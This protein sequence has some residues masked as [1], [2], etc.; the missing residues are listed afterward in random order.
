M[1]FKDYLEQIP[2]ELLH[3]NSLRATDAEVQAAIQKK[4]SSLDDFAALLSPTAIK[5]LEMM[6]MRSQKVT[7]S[8]F[9]KI[10]QL[11]APLYVSNECVDT[12]TYCGFSRENKIARRTLTLSEIENETQ[13][14]IQ[15]GIKHILIVAGEHPH[16]VPPAFFETLIK[17]LKVPSISLEVAPQKESVYCAWVKAGA[18]GL[19]IYQETYQKENYATYHLAGKKKDFDYRLE[20]P[21]RAARAGMKR[22]GIGI[23]LGLS[24]WRKDALALIAH[25]QFLQ[26]Y[27]YRSQITISLPRLRPAA[28]S[29]KPPYPI[30]DHEFVQ[31]I[32]AIRLTLPDTGIVLSTREDSRLR[33]ALIQIGITHMSAG[34]KTEPG[35]YLEPRKAEE[36]FQIEDLRSV[37]E[38]AQDIKA[39]GYEAVLK[40]W[41]YALN[42]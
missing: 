11:Y 7:Q 12:C 8:R 21:E 14:L 17:K 29:F 2:I 3:E 31:L 41:E 30:T 16:A 37:H 24:D 1:T 13:Y 18:D 27:H 42:G 35:G 28:G 40:D 5:H 6:A 26:K 20:T 34:S 4:H 9:G 19:I 15:Q 32:T 22:V 36:Q 33:N 39:A 38:V 25:A 23:L 10:I